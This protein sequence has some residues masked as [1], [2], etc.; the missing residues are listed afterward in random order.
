[1]ENNAAS[2]S[3]DQGRAKAITVTSNQNKPVSDV[4]STDTFDLPTQTGFLRPTS[5]SATRAESVRYTFTDVSSG[6]LFGSG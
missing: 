3:I 4:I 5:E 6:A 2:R 1:M